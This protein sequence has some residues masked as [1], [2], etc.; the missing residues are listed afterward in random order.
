[1]GLLRLASAAASTGCG[2]VTDGPSGLASAVASK[3]PGT[4]ADG[5][6]SLA[7]A[8]GFFNRSWQGN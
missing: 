7:S 5:P 4:V 6:S 8:G 2:T 1:M 3:I